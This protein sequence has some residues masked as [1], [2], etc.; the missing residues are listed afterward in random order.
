V[1]EIRVSVEAQNDFDEIT[2]YSVRTWGWRQADIYLER[3]DDCLELIAANPSI[4]RACDKI[5]S[6]LRRF[7]IGRHVLFYTTERDG[8]LIVR[9]LHQ[10]M[11][12]TEHL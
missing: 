12:P 8:I 5:R 2:T 11:L 4:G 9:V 7:E 10:R 1:N 3:I 6:G